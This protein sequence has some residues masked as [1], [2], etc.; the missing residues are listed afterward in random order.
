MPYGPSLDT[1]C[2]E[3][4]P[5]FTRVKARHP[6][7]LARLWKCLVR[8]CEAIDVEAAH[9]EKTRDFLNGNA[10]DFECRVQGI[11]LRPRTWIA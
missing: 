1:L 8:G 6:T 2:I 11:S 4:R 5:H 9:A 3:P 10:E 7:N